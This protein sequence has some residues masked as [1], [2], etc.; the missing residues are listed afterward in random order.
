MDRLSVRLPDA[1]FGMLDK[2]KGKNRTEK[3]R[4]AIRLAT[5]YNKATDERQNTRPDTT[6]EA[7]AKAVQIKR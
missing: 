2:I 7:E 1:E 6:N 5:K 4:N 3:T